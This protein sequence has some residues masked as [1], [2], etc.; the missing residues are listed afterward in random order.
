M[1]R[2]SQLRNPAKSGE[3]L[4]HMKDSQQRCGG[5]GDAQAETDESSSANEHANVLSGSLYSCR[6][7]HDTAPEENAESASKL[8]H[9]ATCEWQRRKA[10]DALDGVE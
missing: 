10:T 1:R 3:A 7:K 2:K 6:D 9:D 8:V 5:G 4:D